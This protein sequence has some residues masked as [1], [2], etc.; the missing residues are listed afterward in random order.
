MYELIINEKQV[1]EGIKNDENKIVLSVKVK[2]ALQKTHALFNKLNDA[3]E[4]EAML[5][6]ITETEAE[7]NRIL[8]ET[9]QSHP[10]VELSKFG[11]ENIIEGSIRYLFVPKEQRVGDYVVDIITV[12]FKHKGDNSEISVNLP[13]YL[14]TD[15]EQE[16][17]VLM[18]MDDDNTIKIESFQM[19]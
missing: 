19:L 16:S 3:N 8:L 17:L 15:Q 1:L 5:S 11:Y 6:V 14:I 2:E 7:M 9:L 10:L 13:F 12:F 4:N 18:E